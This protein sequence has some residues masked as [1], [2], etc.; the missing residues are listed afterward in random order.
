[1]AVPVNLFVKQGS[2][3]IA[4]VEVH[5]FDPDLNGL[6]IASASTDADGRAAFLVPGTD[7]PGKLYEARFFKVGVRFDNPKRIAV[8]EPV[9]GTTNDFDMSGFLVGDFGIPSNPRLC[10]C[11]GRMLD[12]SE[13]PVRNAVVRVTTDAY[14]LKK[15]PKV[16]DGILISPE[17]METRTDSSGFFILDLLRTGEY[18]VAFSGEMDKLWNIKVPDL[19]S[20]N[21]AELVHP[22]PLV[23]SW[24][25]TG[26]ALSLSV[27]VSVDLPISLLFSDSIIRT[28]ALYDWIEFMNSD[29]DI[30]DVHFSGSILR[31]TGKAA[32]SAVI[33]P[34]AKPD[35]F[36]VRLPT[37][38]LGATEPLN[39]TVLP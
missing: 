33:T 18:F 22:Q 6:F 24:G 37:Y 14:L 12:Y 21:I 1:M 4:T 20:C 35:L 25:M 31:V 30:I 2:D 3:P 11:V 28:E 15:T 19:P 23:M 29:P 26:N 9:V 34:S 27:G 7:D 38:S 36:P 32:G 17:V 8:L 39:I 13:Q 5:L 10:R 16:V